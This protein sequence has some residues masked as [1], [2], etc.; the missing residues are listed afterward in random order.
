LV[1]LEARI[2]AALVA[3]DLRAA[4][5]LAIEGYGPEVLGF[6]VVLLR[7]EDDAREVFAQACQDLWVGL[8]GFERRA[9]MRTWMY[10]LARHAA[11]RLLRSAHRRRKVGLSEVSD[12][13]ARVRTATASYARSEAKAGLAAIRDALDEDDRTLLVLRVDRN[14]AWN[15][16]ATIMLG[17][18]DVTR[19]AARL[20]KRYQHLK[21]E[22][23]AR[24][25]AAGIVRRGDV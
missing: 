7:D 3:S 8:P 16:I 12:L 2:E 6:L 13:V 22:L 25:K 11:A 15:E 10:T 23:R 17:D 19:A 9:T 4:A 1:D 18:E 24:A 14:M 20:R 21:E 5:T